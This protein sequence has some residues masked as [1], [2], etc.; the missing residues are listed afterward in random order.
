MVLASRNYRP[1]RVIERDLAPDLELTVT[2]AWP[3]RNALAVQ[4]E[5][6]DLAGDRAAARTLRSA[7]PVRRR[8]GPAGLPFLRR[9]ARFE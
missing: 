3:V 2:A 5:L 4:F 7:H 9:R 8:A 6:H 1:D